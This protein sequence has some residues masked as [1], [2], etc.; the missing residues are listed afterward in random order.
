MSP[1]WMLVVGF[2]WEIF[3]LLFDKNIIGKKIG[4]CLVLTGVCE[5]CTSQL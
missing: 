4:L 2:E 1:F 3:N 5:S